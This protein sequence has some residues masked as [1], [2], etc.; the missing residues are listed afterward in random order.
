MPSR[1]S[2]TASEESN[3][4]REAEEEEKEEGQ[5]VVVVVVGR[6]GNLPMLR[7]VLLAAAENIVVD[8]CLPT[9]LL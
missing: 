3:L 4:R 1:C 5:L 2:R 8:S 6:S 9:F 7:A